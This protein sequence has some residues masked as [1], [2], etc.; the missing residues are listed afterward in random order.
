M[1]TAMNT[2]AGMG[3][4]REGLLMGAGVG[5]HGP[6]EA[7]TSAGEEVTRRWKGLWGTQ[8]HQEGQPDRPE[9]VGMRG[10]K[11]TG[12]RGLIH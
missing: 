11:A 4:S 12:W 9:V 6:E 2:M 5:F 1:P 7:W 10:G 3:S 8:K